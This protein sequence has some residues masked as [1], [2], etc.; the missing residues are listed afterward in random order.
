MSGKRQHYL[1]QE[2]LRAFAT[3]TNGVARVWTFDKYTRR[4]GC[5]AVHKICQ[6]RQFYDYIELTGQKKKVDESLKKEERKLLV[7]L[8]TLRRRPTAQ[9][10][11]KHR[12]DLARL[13]AHFYTRSIAFR[14]NHVQLLKGM[15]DATPEE[16]ISIPK[17]AA[18]KHD[19]ESYMKETKEG[20]ADFL[21]NIHITL[22]QNDS[23]TPFYSADAPFARSLPIMRG[24]ARILM[25]GTE[26]L[27]S[28]LDFFNEQA[29]EL[30]FPISPLWG[31]AFQDIRHLGLPHLTA[32]LAVVPEKYVEDVNKALVVSSV[33]TVI[34]HR[35]DFSLAEQLIEDFPDVGDPAVPHVKVTV[36][37]NEGIDTA[38]N[39]C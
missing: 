2:Y 29:V 21:S 17:G 15:K 23:T 16:N 33:R 12:G 1:S 5:D 24:T 10:T 38:P 9:V 13:V 22:I 27:P 37:N 11:E 20:F 31:L 19:H 25:D 28:P 8:N 35:N 30:F 34:S 26:V 18:L 6:E 39:Q 4:K 36:R 32:T 7:V 14:R 3:T